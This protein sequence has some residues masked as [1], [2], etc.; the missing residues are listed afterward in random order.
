MGTN[1]TYS[2]IVTGVTVNAVYGFA[3]DTSVV[4]TGATINTV[5]GFPTTTAGVVTNATGT[6]TPVLKLTAQ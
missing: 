6:P 5:W 1:Y 2:G 3:S 4:L